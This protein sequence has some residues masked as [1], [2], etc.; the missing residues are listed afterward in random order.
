MPLVIANINALAGGMFLLSAFGIVVARQVRSALRFFVLQSLFLAAS[1]VT[2]SIAVPGE[3]APVWHLAAIGGIS[4][5][6]KPILVPWLLRRMLAA[7]VYE[8]R[9][10]EQVV[11]ISISLLVALAVTIASYLVTL[12]WIGAVGAGTAA[13]INLPI[14]LSGLLLGAY[15]L[16]VRREAVPQIIGLIAMENGAFFAGVAIAPGLPLFAEMAAA[17]DLL[18]LTFIVGVLTRKVHEQT[19]STTV[20]ELNDLREEPRR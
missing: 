13:K 1:A 10:I 9:E 15:T 8:R 12:P 2:L 20:G 19:G 5:I 4:L 18:I 7:D 17:F 6:T 11:G 14:G 16:A 3:A